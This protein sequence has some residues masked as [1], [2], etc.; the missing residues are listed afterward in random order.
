MNYEKDKACLIEEVKK[1]LYDFL[2]LIRSITHKSKYDKK[3]S[4]SQL[5][6]L[7]QLREYGPYKVNKLAKELGITPSAVTN[8]SDKL[9]TNGFV[10][11]YQPEDNRRVVMLS[12]T[13]K[14]S[15]LIKESDEMRSQ[16]LI[17]SLSILNNCDLKDVIYS[18]SKLNHALKT[19][20]SRND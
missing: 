11:R 7:Y 12:L 8:L 20:K 2:L 3:L 18:F 1:N 13:D 4:I 17:Q 9:V 5:F 6:F 14:G 15:D 10:H 19:Y 16:F